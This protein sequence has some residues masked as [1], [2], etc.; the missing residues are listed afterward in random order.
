[1]DQE[2]SCA[3]SHILFHTTHSQGELGM[4]ESD[5]IVFVVDDDSSVRKALQRLLLSVGMKVETFDGATKFLARLPY[6]GPGCLILDIRMPGLS[7]LD[8]QEELAKTDWALPIVFITGHGT[9]PMSVR[10]MKAG[11]IDFLEKPF[12]DHALLDLIQQ[13]LEYDQKTRNE[14]AENSAVLKR[15]EALTACEQD[16]I[17]WMVAGKLSK[18]VGLK[19][20]ISEKTVKVHRAHVMEKMEAESLADLMRMAEKLPLPKVLSP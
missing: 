17:Q 2:Q 11:A 15:F 1:V 20:G 7:G 19:L 9:V 18:Q 8:L 14:K 10:A 4:T 3:W 12:E 5:P 16:V 13:A 6:T